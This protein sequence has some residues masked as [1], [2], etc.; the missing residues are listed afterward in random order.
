MIPH[1]DPAEDQRRP[2]NSTTSPTAHTTPY[3]T[4]SLHWEEP[5]PFII[6][7][8]EDHERIPIRKTPITMPIA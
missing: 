8:P 6:T 5:P 1:D 7:Q 3:T 2:L 4:D